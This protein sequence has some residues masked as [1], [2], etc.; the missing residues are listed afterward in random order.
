MLTVVL[1]EDAL[2][3]QSDESEI[4]ATLQQV[5]GVANVQFLR[6]KAQN[7]RLRRLLSILLSPES[8]GAEVA[9]LLREI[10]GV[11]SVEIP[12]GRRLKLP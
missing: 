5:V 7:P 12:A 11:E 8:A 2:S 4:L 10:E 1:R 3:S 9:S 6:P